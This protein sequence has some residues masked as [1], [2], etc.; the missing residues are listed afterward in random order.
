MQL[1]LLSS[2][3][4]CQLNERYDKKIFISFFFFF[5]FQNDSQ[6]RFFWFL[7]YIFF[8]N[9]DI[10]FWGVE[11]IENFVFGGKF[12]NVLKILFFLFFFFNSDKGCCC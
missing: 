9:S 11:N 3:I 2:E 6:S 4:N 1:S 10:I 8:L 12:E 7:F 5:S